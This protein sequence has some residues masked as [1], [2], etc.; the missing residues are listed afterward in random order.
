MADA[1]PDAKKE[2]AEEAPAKAKSPLLENKAVVLGIIVVAQVLLA[3]GLTQFLIV[4]KLGVSSADLAPAGEAGGAAEGA[5]EQGALLGL[6]EI[7]V[8]LRSAADRPRYLRINVSLELA[9]ELA[10]EH[11]ATRLPQL[12][13]VVIM[14]LS[15]KTVDDLST[16]GGKQELRDEIMD[17][18]EARLPHGVLQNVYFSDLVIQ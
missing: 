15:D 14:A 11:A 5:H 6:E 13:D 17:S 2:A 12:R 1:K 3:I 16:P 10:V 4:P 9:D 18:L 8:T 7:I